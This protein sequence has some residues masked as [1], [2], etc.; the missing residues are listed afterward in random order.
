M[1]NALKKKWLE[2]QVP[3]ISGQ[4]QKWFPKAQ[5]GSTRIRLISDMGPK[6]ELPNLKS[7]A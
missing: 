2:Y 3:T 1:A 6:L 4:V 7:C 5:N